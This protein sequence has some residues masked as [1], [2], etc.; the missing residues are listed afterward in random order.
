MNKEIE[1]KTEDKSK[2]ILLFQGWCDL[3]DSYRELNNKN[4]TMAKNIIELDEVQVATIKK[5]LRAK[6]APRNNQDVI[7][8]AMDVANNALKY[9]DEE[10]LLVIEP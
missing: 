6:M 10:F 3:L 7:N 1:F 5:R 2:N 9:L 4:N 8:Y